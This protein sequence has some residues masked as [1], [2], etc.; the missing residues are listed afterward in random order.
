MQP[1]S[2]PQIIDTFSGAGVTQGWL[3]QD[4][5]RPCAL[6]SQRP[7]DPVVSK[8]CP[9]LVGTSDRFLVVLANV[10]TERLGASE[11]NVIY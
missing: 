2:G 6:A 1:F 7:Q 11:A 5:G 10:R 8:V 4:Q 9:T 3:G